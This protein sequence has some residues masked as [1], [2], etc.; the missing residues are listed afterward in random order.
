MWKWEMVSRS[1]SGHRGAEKT[2]TR[3]FSASILAGNGMDSPLRSTRTATPSAGA[4]RNSSLAIALAGDKPVGKAELACRLAKSARAV[5]KR[6]TRPPAGPLD[7]AAFP[8]RTCSMCSCARFIIISR[9]KIKPSSL[10]S[11]SGPS[12]SVASTLTTAIHPSSAAI[13]VIG[14]SEMRPNE[15]SEWAV[16]KSDSPK[17]ESTCEERSALLLC[18]ST[19]AMTPHQKPSGASRALSR[20]VEL[21][22]SNADICESASF[23][24]GLS[25]PTAAGAISPCCGASWTVLCLRETLASAARSEVR[26][27]PPSASGPPSS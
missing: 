18:S 9:P 22:T 3:H 2:A 4:T 24:K 27:A 8:K 7:D 5:P 13:A 1:R 19:S 15:R 12:L 14:R 16:R 23:R 25:S 26:R 10:S 20:R 21:A 17:S 6:S 11:I